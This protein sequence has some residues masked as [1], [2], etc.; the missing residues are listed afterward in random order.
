[1]AALNPITIIGGG[2][3]GLTLGIGLRRR[4]IPVTIVEMGHY[5]RHR[6][7]GEFINGRGIE[8][9]ERLELV[10]LL[11]QA[12]AIS[13]RTVVFYSGRTQSPSRRLEMPAL[14]LSRFDLDACL[15]QQFRQLGGELHEGQRFS[16]AAPCEGIVHASGRRA[17]PV[18][19]GWRWFGMKA[20]AQHVSLAADL[21]M[22]VLENGYVG[23][24]RLKGNLVNVCGLFR[25]PSV[26]DRPAPPWQ[27]LLTGPAGTG[28][29]VRMATAVFDEESFCAV[30]GL[31]LRPQRAS[32]LA[33]CS[34]GDALTMNPPVTGNGMSM[35]FE[36]AE[37]ATEPLA[38]YSRGD[39]RWGAAQQAV[40]RACDE[41]FRKRLTWAKWLQWLMFVPALRDRMGAMALNSNLFWRL[42]FAR[43]R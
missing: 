1:M 16:Q 6:I 25:R 28:L 41:R 30:A 24:C 12:G 31:A 27:K 42:M 8:V 17:R 43:T 10:D 2:L 36:S 11:R 15:A 40:A 23:L 32:E 7:C 38:A 37:I 29:H 4:G 19:N 9:L 14:C 35:A 21:E 20:H 5:P 34:I 3:A 39:V 18:E 22:H 33:Q 13:A 26:A